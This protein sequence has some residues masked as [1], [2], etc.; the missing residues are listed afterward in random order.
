MKYTIIRT[1]YITTAIIGISYNNLIT[2]G[3]WLGEPDTICEPVQYT[4]HVVED[5][6]KTSAMRL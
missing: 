3:A 2:N 1:F 5:P 6:K 4:T